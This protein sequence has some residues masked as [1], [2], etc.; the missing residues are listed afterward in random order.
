M[1][2]WGGMIVFIV[3]CSLAGVIF[4]PFGIREV[5]WAG[6]GALALVVFG[7]LPWRLAAQGVGQGGDV[8]LFLAGM[9]GLSELARE[10]GLFDWLAGRVAA[11][12]GGSP[13]RLFGLV[14]GLAVVVTVFL[15]NDA[16]AVVMTPAVAAMTRAAGAKKPFPY[17]LICA[18][19]ANAASF[20]LPISNP[21]NLV[22]FGAKMPRL[23]DWLGGFLVPSVLAVGITFLILFLTQ[24]AALAKIVLVPS[25]AATLSGKGR[26]VGAGLVAT[27]FLLLLASGLGWHLGLPTFVAAALVWVSAGAPWV[28]V[29]HISWS[30]LLLVA[31][32]FV[33]VAGLDFQGIEAAFAHW[34]T[35]AHPDVAF[36]A[37]GLGLGF[38]TNLVNNLPAGLLAGHALHGAPMAL[39]SAALLGVDL[40]PNLSVTGSLATLLWLLALRREGVEISVWRFLR[41]GALVMPPALVVA[42]VWVWFF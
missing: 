6:G 26:L 40:G 10:A 21:A 8:Y 13:Q 14:Y 23:A 9:M 38:G 18:F 24:R 19:V 4:R 28:A 34:L 20:V 11:L 37:L 41:L 30:T 36:W 7:L 29:K 27:V 35:Q 1:R 17:L 12:A 39:Q 32:L 2:I 25:E 31:G 42:L 15:S 22:V 16:T 5:F 33:L 3:L